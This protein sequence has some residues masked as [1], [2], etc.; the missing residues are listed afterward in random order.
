MWQYDYDKWINIGDNKPGK[1]P[2]PDHWWNR[3]PEMADIE[4]FR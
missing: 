4:T 1:H 3:F 2:D